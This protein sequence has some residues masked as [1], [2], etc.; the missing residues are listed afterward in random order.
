MPYLLSNRVCTS[1]GKT[2]KLF[3]YRWHGQN[4]KHLFVSKCADC[5]KA[6]TKQHQQNNREYWRELNK[7]SYLNKVGEY[8]RVMN[9]TEEDRKQRARDKSN[10][11]CGRAKQA[12]F[13]DELTAFVTQ[14]AHSLRK[15]RNSVTGFEWHV[16]HILPLKGKEVCGLHIWNNLQ[17]IPASIN[18]SKGNKEM[19]NRPI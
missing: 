18:L 12:R 15:L 5:E 19:T 16:D 14:E 6:Y 9:R 2:D 17:V 8:S 10:R 11:R 7:K 13:T 1:C 3:R 4:Q